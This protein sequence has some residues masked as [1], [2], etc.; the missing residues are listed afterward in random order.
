[1]IVSPL[2]SPKMLASP[3]KSCLYFVRDAKAAVCTDFIKGCRQI[4]FRILHC[5]TNTLQKEKN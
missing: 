3:A 2:E 4:A 1:M 5:S